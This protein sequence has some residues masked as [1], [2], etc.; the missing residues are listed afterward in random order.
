MVLSKKKVSNETI[1]RLA[2]YLRSLHKLQEI[3][4]DIVSSGQISANLNVSPDQFRKDLSYF[5]S[6][7]KRGVGY[8]VDN[9]IKHLE[10]ILGIDK[11]CR[12]IIV[13]VGKLGSALLAYPGFSNFN[14]RIVSAFD[15]DRKKVGKIINGIKIEEMENISRVVQK[16]E[17]HL[18]VLT[19]PSESAQMVATKLAKCGIKGILNFAPISLNLSN[20][21][22]ILNV[23]VATELMTLRYLSRKACNLNTGSTLD[24]VTENFE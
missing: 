23:D 7:G 2:L 21:I 6:L 11:E 1:R 12:V 13:G 18:A 19:V 9:L 24:R 10:K 20:S 15:N 5:G 3:N 14:F 22:R 16:L 8:R 4:L 17:V